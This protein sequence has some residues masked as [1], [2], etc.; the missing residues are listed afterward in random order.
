MHT[1]ATE[2]IMKAYDG[3]RKLI[4]NKDLLPEQKI[5]QEK[6]AAQLGVSRTPLRSALRMLEGENLVVAIP[7]RGM[8][9]RKFTTKEV[10]E[11]YEC[12]AA[13]EGVA[14]QL[15]A[16]RN[17]PEDIKE[18]RAFFAPFTTGQP[19]DRDAYRIADRKF[20]ETIISKCGN[21]YLKRLVQQG[22]LLL[23]IDMIG[24]V[25]PPEET[26]GEHLGIIK[27]I[28]EGDGDR[29]KALL[30][31]HLYKSQKELIDG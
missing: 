28:E 16:S 1:S 22:S 5:V 15:F 25:W 20:H 9:V 4:L 26:I 21:D 10:I 2:Q 14:C 7:R 31:Q 12:R 3:I 13:L 23:S 17:T 11:V 19:I 8:F 29:A 24:V 18:L 27:A 6:L 30:H